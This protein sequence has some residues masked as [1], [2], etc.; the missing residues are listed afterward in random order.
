TSIQNA[1]YLLMSAAGGGGLYFYYQQNALP[2]WIQIAV[3]LFWLIIVPLW[4]KFKWRIRAN[5]VGFL[6]GWLLMIPFWQALISLRPD[7][8]AATA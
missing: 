2:L 7:T 1:L 6:I 4:L 3:L 5:L 8:Q